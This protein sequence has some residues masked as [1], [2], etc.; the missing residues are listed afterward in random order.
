[1][2]LDYAAGWPGIDD[3][4]LELRIDGA[5]LTA[6]VLKGR[7]YTAQFA[8]SKFDVPDLGAAVPLLRIEGD[9]QR[10]GARFHPLRR[11]QPARRRH[12]SRDGRRQRRRRRQA[13]AEARA[14]AGPARRPTAS[15]ART[16]RPDT[17]IALADGSPPI[18]HLNG[19]LLF[20]GHD[21][22]APELTAEVLGLPARLSIATVDGHARVEGQGSV[23]FAALRAQYP[24]QALLT[25]ASGTTD[26]KAIVSAQP[27]GLDLERRVDAQRRQH[28][29]AAARRQ[30]RIRRARVPDRASPRRSRA[31]PHHRKLRTRR[32]GRRRAQAGDAGRGHG[33][34]R[35]LARRGDAGA[36]AAR[37]LDSRRRR[38]A[39]R[40]RVADRQ[41]ATRCGRR[42]R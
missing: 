23:S 41:G 11:Q 32:Q 10:A 34:R 42:S 39:R 3:M 38:C 20:T 2:T 26:W 30:S 7:I 37:V 35:A 12:A 31:R 33:A 14:G 13:R 18:E 6:D 4:D 16:P 22:S 5:R 36:A 28:R 21:V 17:R 24:K 40:R 19:Q 1:M 8:R 25:R 9:G 29:S 27:S 15:R